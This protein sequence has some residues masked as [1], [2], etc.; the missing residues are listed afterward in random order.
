MRELALKKLQAANEKACNQDDV[1]IIEGTD[2]KDGN[3]ASLE[4]RIIN[5]SEK[6]KVFNASSLK[7][8][9]G[10]NFEVVDIPVPITAT[11]TV[12]DNNF[13]AAKTPP[14]PL[15]TSPEQAVVY[16][17]P[18]PI[19]GP[20][21]ETTVVNNTNFTSSVP[22][23]APPTPLPQ[24]EVVSSTK[25]PTQVPAIV[26][27]PVP[28]P[29]PATTHTPAPTPSTIA[30][31]PNLSVPPPPLPSPVPAPNSAIAKFNTP[32][33]LIPIKSV[34]PPKPPIVAF[35]TKS[36]SKLPLPPGI[37]QND[38]ESIDS[39]PS[40]SPS[41][42]PRSVS[43]FSFTPAKPPVRKSIKDLPMP[44]GS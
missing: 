32:N 14:L 5:D 7:D 1:Q 44:P 24:S 13:V 22:L 21:C 9:N 38:L 4:N 15:T 28:A 34:D 8:T 23:P 16:S 31:L 18:V 41:P 17:S 43:K 40:R 2:E 20:T 3:N 37:N 19:I 27:I 10:K 36:L 25:V 29:A 42:P 11:L 39:P 35:K 33:N 12:V 26:P 30:I 6:D